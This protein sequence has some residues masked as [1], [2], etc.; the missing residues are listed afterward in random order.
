MDLSKLS[1][2]ELRAL[3]GRQEVARRSVADLSDEELR[4]LSAPKG[5]SQADAWKALTPEQQRKAD[6]ASDRNLADYAATGTTY[7]FADKARAQMRSMVTGMPYDAA[8]KEV[9]GEADRGKDMLGWKANAAEIAGGVGSGLAGAGAGLTAARFIPQ[10]MTGGKRLMAL[11]GAGAVD[12]AALGALSG[13]GNTDDGEYTR[14]MA[15]QAAIGGTIG[16]IAPAVVAGAGKA[17]QP[18]IDAVAS[19]VSPEGFAKRLAGRAI[20]RSGQPVDVIRTRLQQAADDG[21]PNYTAV[22]AMG[23]GGARALNTITRGSSPSASRAKEF[24]D[25]R[26]SDQANRMESYIREGL[27]ARNT[28]QQLADK[29][30]GVRSEKADRA[31]PEAAANSGPVDLSRTLATIDTGI[32][33]SGLPSTLADNPIQAALRGVRGQITNGK[34]TLTDFDRVRQLFMATRDSGDEA[35]RSGAG[36]KGKMLGRTADEMR[37]ALEEAYPP[38]AKAQRDYAN[39]S[40]AMEA[41]DAGKGLAARGV[42]QDTADAFARMTPQEAGAART[43]YADKLVERLQRGAEGVNAGRPLTSEKFVQD[44]PVVARP[45]RADKLQRQINREQ[46]MFAT[47]ATATGGS[48]TAQNLADI[49][50]VGSGGA[51]D[52]F[53][54]GGGTGLGAAATLLAARRGLGKLPVPE[55]AA[56]E[57]A[58][59]L[60]SRSADDVASIAAKRIKG[61]EVS[62]QSV[63]SLARALG[64]VGIGAAQ[65]STP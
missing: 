13:A 46:E 57:L 48:N 60:L 37:T 62:E 42:T 11:M 27:G 61:R 15:E 12:G 4:A 21:V 38:F 34:E 41:I 49:A 39:L 44:L 64:L 22:D 28:A 50:A 35:F 16:G 7:G 53:G 36:A 52:W 9:R 10:A 40:S 2:D 5:F 45:G 1:D 56:E 29:L 55:K 3:A 17:V 18:V 26:Q 25:A 31:Y 32:S 30:K 58:R 63:A 43:G 23:D 65:P 24:L 51:Y 14:R 8:I 20:E 33:P 59:A 47:R 54:G 6:P 19:R